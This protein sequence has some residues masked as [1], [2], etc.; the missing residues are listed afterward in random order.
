MVRLKDLGC[1]EG[2]GY[3]FSKPLPAK[4]FQE[5]LQKNPESYFEII[6]K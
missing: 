1:K 2:Q 3:W 6:K 5:L 4:E